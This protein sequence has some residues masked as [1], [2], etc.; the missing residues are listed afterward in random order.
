MTNSKNIRPRQKANDQS[1]VV[2]WSESNSDD[3]S[4]HES[5]SPVFPV[6]N[7]VKI[8][9]R[10]N[11]DGTYLF[12]VHNFNTLDSVTLNINDKWSLM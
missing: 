6:P 4:K 9:L 8:Y 2:T 12:R 3:F 11:T 5:L 10:P 7:D 1:V